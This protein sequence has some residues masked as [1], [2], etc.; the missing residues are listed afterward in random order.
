MQ[1]P[2]MQ[3]PHGQQMAMTP[4]QQQQRQWLHQQMLLRQQQQGPPQQ[5]IVSNA[6]TNGPTQQFMGFNQ[7]SQIT[8][9]PAMSQSLQNMGPNGGQPI[10]SQ[11]QSQS[12]PMGV[13]VTNNMMGSQMSNPNIQSQVQQQRFSARPG[14]VSSPM[15]PPT[16]AGPS[17]S[18][19]AM[20]TPS[21][22][23]HHPSTPSHSPHPIVG[24]PGTPQ[25]DI[26][27]PPLMTDDSVLTP[28]E[29]LSKYVEQL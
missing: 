13:P 17:A 28:Q 15:G 5:Q 9:N 25:L 20:P 23:P 10:T 22:R 16:P 8:G 27:Q 18:P 26:L 2:Q 11:L 29:Q 24:G 1:H 21:P 6:S 12:S 4:Q 14:P 19:R 3:Q 7:G